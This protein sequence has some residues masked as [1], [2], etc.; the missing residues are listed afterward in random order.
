[1]E[2]DVRGQ[3]RSVHRLSMD[4]KVYDNIAS[5][6]KAVWRGNSEGKNW[7]AKIGYRLF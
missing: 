6:E 4:N 2:G 7:G 5:A 1:M 3:S